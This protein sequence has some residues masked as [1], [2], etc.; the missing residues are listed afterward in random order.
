MPQPLGISAAGVELCTGSI[1][2]FELHTKTYRQS[3]YIN[4]YSIVMFLLMED[5]W[6]TISPN[7]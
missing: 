5:I 4:P 1:S 2:L 6:R 3:I 7:R